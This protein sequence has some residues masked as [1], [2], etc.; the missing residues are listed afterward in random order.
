MKG[1]CAGAI[2]VSKAL[3]KSFTL[4]M[5]LLVF[6]KKGGLTEPALCSHGN[7]WKQRKGPHLCIG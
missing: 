3:G 2:A 4:E 7:S 6:S 1:S 5:K